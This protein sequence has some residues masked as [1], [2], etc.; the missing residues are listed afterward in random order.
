MI[1]LC[2][3]DLPDQLGG[4]PGDSEVGTGNG[5]SDVPAVVDLLHEGNLGDDCTGNRIGEPVA[6]KTAPVPG[7]VPLRKDHVGPVRVQQPGLVVA[8]ELGVIGSGEVR[9]VE[10]IGKDE[11]LPAGERTVPVAEL[12]E[13]RRF[14]DP[15]CVHGRLVDER[16]EV[17]RCGVGDIHGRGR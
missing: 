4:F 8:R 10:V 9:Y 5:G 17:F 11:E 2:G 16:N 15:L 13:R 3:K 6:D 14:P 7:R 1:D 12:A